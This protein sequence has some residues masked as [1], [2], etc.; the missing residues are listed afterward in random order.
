MSRYCSRHQ[1][2]NGLPRQFRRPWQQPQRQPGRNSPLDPFV[3]VMTKSLTAASSADAAAKTAVA[4]ASSLGFQ[5]FGAAVAFPSRRCNREFATSIPLVV[6]IS[7]NP[8]R[9]DSFKLFYL[10]GSKSISI[11]DTNSIF[12]RFFCYSFLALMIESVSPKISGCQKY[13]AM[14]KA[15][16]RQ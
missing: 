15:F 12:D 8:F 10:M 4:A 16:Q 3:W 9:S 13:K 7:H 1:S 11:H 14:P 6:A 5:T 2:S